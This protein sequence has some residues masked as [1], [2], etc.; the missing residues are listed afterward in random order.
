MV[1]GIKP[2]VFTSSGASETIALDSPFTLVLS[3]Q[4]AVYLCK[5]KINTAGSQDIERWT[6]LM[7]SLMQ[8]LVVRKQKFWMKPPDGTLISGPGLTV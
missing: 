6:T 3:A 8:E 1:V 4:A 2:L 7:Q 5:Q